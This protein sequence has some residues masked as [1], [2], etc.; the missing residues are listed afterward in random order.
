M[1]SC[2]KRAPVHV[3]QHVH[4][5]L[6]LAPS[7]LRHN[8][9]IFVP[10]LSDAHKVDVIVSTKKSKTP[11]HASLYGVHGV[12]GRMFP[13]LTVCNP[14]RRAVMELSQHRKLWLLLLHGNEIS[15][16]KALA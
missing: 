3:L 15:G 9:E 13:S 10:I 16:S 6:V 4:T 7:A 8:K 14:S 2:G 1:Q 11:S 12:H 5:R